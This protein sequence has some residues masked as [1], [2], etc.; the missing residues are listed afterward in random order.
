[1]VVVAAAAVVLLVVVV[2]GAVVAVVLLALGMLIVLIIV[3][4]LVHV[5]VAAA[6]WPQINSKMLAS[7]KQQNALFQQLP[8]SSLAAGLAHPA[9]V[10]LGQD[11]YNDNYPTITTAIQSRGW[12]SDSCH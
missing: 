3:L 10:V 9:W 2:V 5:V 11:Y 12:Q 4:V 6:C 7:N 8:E 1:M